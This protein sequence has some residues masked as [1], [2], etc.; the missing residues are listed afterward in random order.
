MLRGTQ[1]Y[2]DVCVCTYRS[3]MLALGVHFQN[4]VYLVLMAKGP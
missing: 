2:I 4:T 3:Q 1:G